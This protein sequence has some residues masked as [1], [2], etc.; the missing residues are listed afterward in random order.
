VFV[1]PP[2]IDTRRRR[3]AHRNGGAVHLRDEARRSR[4]SLAL[5]PPRIVA[6][7]KTHRVVRIARP[8]TTGPP[9]RA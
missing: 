4:P 3:S 5:R 6:A 8:P 2:E 1:A 7:W 9:V